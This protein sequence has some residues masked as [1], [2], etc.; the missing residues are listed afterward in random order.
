VTVTLRHRN[1]QVAKVVQWDQ[2]IFFYGIVWWW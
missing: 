1:K 2:L